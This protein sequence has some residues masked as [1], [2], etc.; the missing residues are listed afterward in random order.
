[1]LRDRQRGVSI[2]ETMIVVT[3]FAILLVGAMPTA[4][5]WLANSRIR[6]A[7]ESVLAGLQLA[8]AEAVKRNVAVEFVLDA[9]PSVGWTVRTAL[10]GEVIQTRAAGEGTFD[11]TVA[12]TPGGA[13][14]VSFDG[15]GRRTANIDASVP[16]DS[17]SV[18]LPAT[19]LAADKTRDLRLQLGLGGQVLVCDPN[20][21]AVGDVRKCP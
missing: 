6:T 5:Q 13:T 11:V 21:A 14:R 12:A 17:M 15:L 20:V 1:M 10:S 19:V 18:D 2:I 8:R 9:P 7:T 4:Q 3:V 16:L